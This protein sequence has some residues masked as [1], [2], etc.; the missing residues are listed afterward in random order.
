MTVVVNDHR[1]DGRCSD[2]GR[3]RWPLDS[4]GGWPSLRMTGAVNDYHGGLPVVIGV[5]N[6]RCSERGGG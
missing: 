5:V 1:G 2:D 3:G 4:Y 6:D